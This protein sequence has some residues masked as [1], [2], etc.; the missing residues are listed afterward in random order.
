MSFWYSAYASSGVN[1]SM[2]S[3]SFSIFPY[4]IGELWQ[5]YGTGM[6]FM[7]ISYAI[8][9]LDLSYKICYTWQVV[10]VGVGCKG[11]H[12]RQFGI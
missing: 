5:H 8:I 4:Y 7:H 9:T 12:L 11:K 10:G 2:S 1:G 6:L 3:I